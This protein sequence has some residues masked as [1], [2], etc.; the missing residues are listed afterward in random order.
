MAVAVDVAAD[1]KA[2]VAQ[3]VHALVQDG[4]DVLVPG[5]ALLVLG[6]AP[7]LARA[8]QR[9]VLVTADDD[10]PALSGRALRHRKLA[11]RLHGV[12]L[13][14]RQAIAHGAPVTVLE[15]RLAH[16]AEEHADA[17]EGAVVVREDGLELLH[18]RTQDLAEI[19]DPFL[20]PVV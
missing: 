17:F 7:V 4:L 15:D 20:Q 6:A 3:E 5:A 10:A 12:V 14:Y 9:Q 18:A 2:V 19:T 11:G 8:D 1:G 13:R 16:V